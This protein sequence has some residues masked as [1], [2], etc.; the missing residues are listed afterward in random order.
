MSRIVITT[1]TYIGPDLDPGRISGYF[2]SLE[3]AI[4]V[5]PEYREYLHVFVV[6]MGSSFSPDL[7]SF[8]KERIPNL[9]IINSGINGKRM[10]RCV[11]KIRNRCIQDLMLEDDIVCAF[12][13]DYVFNPYCFKFIKMVYD[14]NPEVNF[15]SVLKP[16]ENIPLAF[17]ERISGLYW[18]KVEN[19]MGGSSTYRW[20]E[21][22]KH[23]YAFFEEYGVTEDEPGE[24]RSFDQF[25]FPFVSKRVG[26][27]C[28]YH[29]MN[30]SLC[31]HTNQISYW[32]N[33]RGNNPLNHMYG[34]RYDPLINP[35]LIR[36]L[37][38]G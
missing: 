30:F 17:L 26:G 22:S 20:K 9:E 7:I 3:N 23:I 10:A 11:A 1:S 38:G 5:V 2:N 4:A 29:L 6:T 32:F 18:W 15:L 19:S 37:L 14:E 8:L 35:F 21:F 13:D 34:D 16:H 27:P 36:K 25:F 24:A 12:D 33:V 31:Q 28:I